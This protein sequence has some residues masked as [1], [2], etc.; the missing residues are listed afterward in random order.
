MP[1]IEPTP[2]QLQRLRDD[3]AEPGRPEGWQPRP[4]QTHQGRKDSSSSAA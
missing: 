1:S 2:E 3:V 4:E